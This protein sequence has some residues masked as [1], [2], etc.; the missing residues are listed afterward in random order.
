M[1]SSWFNKPS[2]LSWMA[3][4]RNG[5]VPRAYAA[6]YA[7]HVIVYSNDATAT[8]STKYGP[9]C[10]RPYPLSAGFLGDMAR[11]AQTFAGSTSGPPLYVTMFTEFQTY[12]CKRN[13]WAPDAAT[14]NYYL[15][16]QDQ[17][18]AA[19]AVFHQY[20]PNARVSL[21]WGGWQAS[22]DDPAIGGGRSMFGYFDSVMRMS[23]FESFQ[24][25]DSTSN[26][27][28]VE[29]MVGIL[30]RYGPVMLAHYKPNNGSPAVF[31]A[32]LRTML[33]DDFLRRETAAGLFAWSFMDSADLTGTILSFAEAAVTRFGK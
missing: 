14:R 9:A 29:Q 24:A 28:Q 13:A 6:G 17:Y 16:L 22:W 18:R 3:G 15:A 12:P 33:T 26:V 7:L 5:T 23:D 32:D 31:N 20:A 2:D 27:A 8:V 25:M 21:G 4:W 11:L 19:Y 10:G 30:G 1:L